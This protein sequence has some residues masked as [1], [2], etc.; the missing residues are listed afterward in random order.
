MTR[1]R[2]ARDIAVKMKSVHPSESRL[3]MKHSQ[4]TQSRSGTG[5]AWNKKG[6]PRRTLSATSKTKSRTGASNGGLAAKSVITR[7]PTKS[8]SKKTAAKVL[9]G[10]T[11]FVFADGKAEGQE[12]QKDLLG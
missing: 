9:K 7:V 3:T 2:S 4:Q 5:T 10:K 12:H 6:S 11:V 1:D 8:V